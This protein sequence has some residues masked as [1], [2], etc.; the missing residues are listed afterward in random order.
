[1]NSSQDVLTSARG[2]WTVVTKRSKRVWRRRRSYFTLP[3]CLYKNSY[4]HVLLE[5]SPGSDEDEH[6]LHTN[7]PTTSVDFPDAK[8]HRGRTVTSTKRACMINRCAR[9]HRREQGFANSSNTMKHNSPIKFDESALRHDY[10][11]GVVKN[12]RNLYKS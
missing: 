6:I 1:M 10:K 2:E 12:A 5:D 3:A 9:T 8:L 11:P 7:S 4:F